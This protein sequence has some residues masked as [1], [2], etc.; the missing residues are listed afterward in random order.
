MPAASTR[1]FVETARRSLQPVHPYRDYVEWLS[2]QRFDESRAFWRE[3]LAGFREPTLLPGERPEWDGTGERYARHEVQL[4]VDVSGELKVVARRLQATLSTLVQG[5]WGLLLH[6][7]SGDN[8]IVFG[9]AFSGRPSDLPGVESIVG[10]FVNN[11]PVR[12]GVNGGAVGDLFQ[13]LHSRLLTVNQ[14][15]FTPLIDI[16]HA[17]EVPFR[18]RLFDSL[19]VFQNYLVDESARGFG[20]EIGIADFSGPVHTNYPVLLLAEPGLALRLT[21][22]YDRQNVAQSTAEAWGA[23]LA[24]LLERLPVFIDRP[25]A[26]LLATLSPPSVGRRARQ[27]F[28]GQSL[29][30]VP[31]QTEMEHTIAGVWKTMFGMDQVGIEENFFDLGGHSL[32]LV[33]MYGRLREILNIEFPIITLFEYPTIHSL[34]RHLSNPATPNT[35]GAKQWKDL[36]QRQKQAFAQLRVKLK[37]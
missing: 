25:A 15:Q 19:V 4:T 29:N 10:P 31:P 30:L 7:Q 18:Y 5:A 22:I 33:Q 24:V 3:T 11:L 27:K 17:S 37:K 1:P 26:E 13:Q 28:Q 6:R 32:L 23:D 36:A 35:E 34:A 16:Q 21:L 9:A 8:D 20:G 14:H 2:R 12:F